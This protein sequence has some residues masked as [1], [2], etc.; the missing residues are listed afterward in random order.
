MPQENT[1]RLIFSADIW[2][3]WIA[4]SNHDEP[5][6]LCETAHVIFVHLTSRPDT[7]QST[8]TAHLL[9]YFNESYFLQGFFGINNYQFNLD[10]SWRLNDTMFQ[11]LFNYSL[12]QVL[13]RIMRLT[14]K[15]DAT[16]IGN[17]RHTYRAQNWITLL[18]L[19]ACPDIVEKD[20]ELF[21]GYLID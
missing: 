17:E 9:G 18:L 1:D 5:V 16:S 14:V 4:L 12:V 21:R 8:N 3:S 19:V 10:I 6:P 7:C 20:E 13:N 15:K 11:A 2:Q